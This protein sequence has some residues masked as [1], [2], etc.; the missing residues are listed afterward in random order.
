MNKLLGITKNDDII[1]INLGTA[2]EVEDYANG[3]SDDPPLEPM[4]LYLEGQLLVEWNIKLCELFIEH[5]AEA[6]DWEVTDYCR[7][8]LETAF[9]NRLSTLQ[10]NFRRLENKTDAQIDE[11]KRTSGKRQRASSRRDKVGFLLMA[12]TQ[13]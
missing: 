2:D 9:K 7:D 13:D 3:T 12:K 10:K 11:E 1:N 4:H 6:E 8:V 5:L